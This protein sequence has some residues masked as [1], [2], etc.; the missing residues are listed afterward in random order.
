[1]KLGHIDYLNSYPFYHHMFEQP[2]PGVEI[3]SG[4]PSELNAR[5]KDGRLHMSPISAAA[6][7]DIADEVII[8][9]DFCLGSVGY[10]HSVILV[11]KRPIE[12]LDGA[13]VGLTSASQTSVALLKTLLE[14]Y[15]DVTPDYVV[16]PPRPDLSG[17][18]DAAL[19]IGNEAMMN[20]GAV[21]YT[22]DLGDLWL[23]KTGFPVVFA[24]FAVRRDAL[25]GHCEE[26]K[27][28]INSYHDSYYQGMNDQDTLITAARERYPDIDYDISTYYTLMKYE[29]TGQLKKAL[30]FY[31]QTAGSLG[32]VARV[33]NISFMPDDFSLSNI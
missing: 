27:A 25:S 23:R 16:T 14:K 28:V 19:I 29:F 22:Y 17:D 18:L 12:D 7:A 10:V 9:P 11:S 20:R 4:H 2:L 24:V 5:M 26:I 6:Y 30:G 3:F 15:Y 31:L 33:D 8:L 13:R 32:H 21:P 1:M